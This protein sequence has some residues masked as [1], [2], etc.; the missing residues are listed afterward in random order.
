MAKK[1]IEKL[2]ENKNRK[3]EEN[4]DKQNK[5]GVGGLI[6]M[7]I[8]SWI[9]IGL[10]AYGLHQLSEPNWELVEGGRGCKVYR[11]KGAD[12]RNVGDW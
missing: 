2:T 12:Y 6:A 11:E 7:Y 4:L 9:V 10:T 3:L 8:A 1:T 5:D